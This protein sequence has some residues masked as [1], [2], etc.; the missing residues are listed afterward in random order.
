MK[1]EKYIY[2][3]LLIALYA[4]F[5]ILSW[6]KWGHIIYDCFRE[7][8]IPDAL[9]N[10]QIL[11]KDI[12]NLYPPLAYQV[13]AVLYL[14]FG[15]SLN[16]LYWAGIVN[17]FLILSVVYFIIKRYSSGV[18]AFITVLSIMEIF[19]F[20]MPFTA[21]SWIFSYSYS[22]IYAFSFCLL[23]FLFYIL[24]KE[25]PVKSRFLLLSFFFAGL[26]A[27]FKFDFILF[28]FLPLYDAIKTAIKDKSL[29]IVLYGVLIYI[30]PVFVSFGV[31]IIGAWFAGFNGFNI[32]LD[33]VNFLSDFSKS[34]SVIA[35]NKEIMPQTFNLPVLKVVF[36]SFFRFILV[37]GILFSYTYFCIF[38]L[39]K[40]KNLVS[41]ILLGICLYGLG[42]SLIIVWI[43]LYQFP[44]F[45]TYGD[46]VFLSYF[47]TVSA[48]VIT[49]LKHIKRE[50]MR[51]GFS[52]KQKFYLLTTVFALL[53]SFRCFG[54][55]YITCIGNFI[56]IVWWFLFIYFF[57]EILPGYFPKIFKKD[58]IKK[59][60]ILFFAV[61]GLY[62]TFVYFLNSMKL[63]YKINSGKGV[64]YVSAEHNYTIKEAM[65]FIDDNIPKGK[66]LLV[67]EEGLV[68]NYFTNR[69]S[70]LKYYAL[71]P[72]MV[73]AYGEE[74]VIKGLG[75]NLP[76]YVFI[77]NDKYM[78]DGYFGIDYAKKIYGYILENYDYIK[79][80]KN[81]NANPAFANN[82][83][84][85]IFKL[86]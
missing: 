45:S 4:I 1:N 72:H 21:G 24:Y 14:I 71:I 76:D 13:N 38:L 84:I 41:K 19:T 62:F 25:N 64:Y 80:I 34:P 16:T 53:I 77:T 7:A 61:F 54:A 59:A 29:K 44:L 10:G 73:E 46:L 5:I 50:R 9:L 75:K 33:W 70:N 58:I 39:S 22:F 83:E 31:F 82:F 8:I 60:L 65:G 69:K 20:K 12:T 26:S 36:V 27:A 15:N 18:V 32:L 40:M 3:L 6:G 74:N 85:R 56:L 78:S 48:F 55:I 17:S 51:T 42:Y 68:L 28:G 86:R 79:T 23:G 57:V 2:P 37:L 47:V 52:R 35:Y 43:A 11:Y 66:T 63:S 67:L 49:V 81:P 30:L